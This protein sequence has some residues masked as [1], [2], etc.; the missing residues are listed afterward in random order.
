M[1]ILMDLESPERPGFDPH[2][3]EATSLE[4]VEEGSS[5]I[6][7]PPSKQ[8]RSFNWRQKK[9]V[10]TVLLIICTL[11][12]LSVAGII[13]V[14]HLSSVN[15]PT[16]N[17]TINT[18]SL[19][20]GTLNQLTPA[21]GKTKE[22]LT[23][24]PDT[25]FKNSTVVQGSSQVIKDLS[26]GGSLDVQG[27]AILRDSLT[28]GKSLSVGTN[29]TVNG[30]ITAASLNVG[31]IAISSI[32]ISGNLTFGGHLSPNGSPPSARTSTAAG[33]GSVTV[34]GN[35]TAGTIIIKTGGG[36]LAAG[37]MA[38]ITFSSAFSTTPKVQLT[39]VSEPASSLRYYATKS[40]SFFTINTGN[41]PA[42]GTTYIFDYLVTQ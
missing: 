37:E 41:A 17:V 1:M 19:D 12:G 8:P 11:L 15:Q 2:L 33:G 6:P 22:Q 34:S 10:L 7:T 39:P 20:N 32:N 9:R 5:S 3:P 25:I 4:V 31:S 35:D 36:G 14:K 26:V 42:A 24:S 28:I 40:A 16:T 27:T 23:I 38:V 18:Q 21:D 29:L 30:L 13:F